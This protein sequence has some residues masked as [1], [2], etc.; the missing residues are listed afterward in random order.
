MKA[1]PEDVAAVAAQEPTSFASLLGIVGALRYT[2][3]VTVH[4]L[5]GQPQT[6]E[7]GRPVVVSF[8]EHPANGANKKS[9]KSQN[10]VDSEAGVAAS[11]SP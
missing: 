1:T 4:F 8:P 7:L 11:S 3:A 6:A 9:A 10:P 5:N 2:G